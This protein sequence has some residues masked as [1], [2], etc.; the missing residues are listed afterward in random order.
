MKKGILLLGGLLTVVLVM[1]Y[2]PRNGGP[3]SVLDPATQVVPVENIYLPTL[4]IQHG[5]TLCPGDFDSDAE[6]FCEDGSEFHVLP[7]FVVIARK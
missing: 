3:L 6:T 5:M 1:V 7:T 4:Y 2:F